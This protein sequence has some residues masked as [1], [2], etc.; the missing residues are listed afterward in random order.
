MKV[1]VYEV[2]EVTDEERVAIA[3]RLDGAGAKKRKASAGEMKQWLWEQGATW[4]TVLG[5]GDVSEPGDDLI[6]DDEAEPD[7]L[8]DLI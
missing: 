6:G 4:R 8:E 3:A 2:Q 5:S 7:P 1:A